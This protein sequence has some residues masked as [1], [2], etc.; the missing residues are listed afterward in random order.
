M[1]FI[2]EGMTTRNCIHEAVDREMP[3]NAPGRLGDETYF[4]TITILSWL[5]PTKNRTKLPFCNED[6]F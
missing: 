1:P 2:N 6:N 5:Q 4:L 3:N